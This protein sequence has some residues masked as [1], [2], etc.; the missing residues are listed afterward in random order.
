[1]TYIVSG[2]SLN[3]TY[4]PLAEGCGSYSF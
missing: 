3:F 2:G 1:M 4:S